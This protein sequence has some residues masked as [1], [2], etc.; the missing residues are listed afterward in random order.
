M[1]EMVTTRVKLSGFKGLAATL[2]ALPAGIGKKTAM[3]ALKEAAKPLR[4]G[5][6]E[7]VARGTVA[8]HIAD[9]IIVRSVR[10]E[11]D[12]A[13]IAVGPASKFFY[14]WFLEKGR[15][16]MAAQP[17]VRPAFAEWAPNGLRLLREAFWKRI[18]RLARKAA[19]GR[20]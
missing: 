19:K 3:S 18:R 1:P 6:A 14:G 2:R 13:T 16:G 4:A 7:R 10:E 12:R 9:K 17:W 15:S 5:M 20:R 8:P 11:G